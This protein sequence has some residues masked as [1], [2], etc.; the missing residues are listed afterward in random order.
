M[1]QIRFDDLARQT[2]S[3]PPPGRLLRL[4]GATLVGAALAG[5]HLR[6]RPAR[7]AVCPER[8]PYYNYTPTTNGCGPEGGV[9]VPGSIWGA[10]FASACNGHDVCYGT[11]N[12]T[13]EHCD[14]EFRDDLHA[15]CAAQGWATYLLTNCAQIADVYYAAV[16]LGGQDAYETAQRDACICCTEGDACGPNS[17][18]YE[19]CCRAA[20]PFCCHGGCWQVGSIDCGPYCCPPKTTCCGPQQNCCAE[21]FVCKQGCSGP[22]PFVCCKVGSATCCPEGH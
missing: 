8:V 21:G 5:R 20:Q 3:S 18:G 15:A 13:Q 6:P 9:N 2:T 12:R 7:A 19:Y 14:D 1:D 17:A 4:V 16:A 11:C 22:S 10:D